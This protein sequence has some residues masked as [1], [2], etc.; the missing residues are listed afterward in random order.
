[1][2]KTTASKIQ[3]SFLAFLILNGLSMPIALACRLEAMM[4]PEKLSPQVQKEAQ[5]FYLRS[6][7][8]DPNSL[9]KE[10][11]KRPQKDGRSETY[12]IEDLSGIIRKYGNLDGWGL[13]GYSCPIQPIR[14]PDSS[15]SIEP[16]VSDK[17][18]QPKVSKT[19]AQNPNIIM[20]HVRQAPPDKK[21]VELENVHPFT[22]QSWSLM[23]NGGAD[24]AF[25]PSIQQTI[26]R[27]KAELGGGPKGNT[28][29][30]QI[31][32]YFLSTLL[33]QYGTTDSAKLTLNQTQA[34]FAKTMADIVSAS[35]PNAKPIHG[36]VI[37][38]TGTIQT[39]P[40]C[41]FIL[42]DGKHLLAFRKVL[43]LFLG[44]KTLPNGQK[45]YIIASEKTHVADRT[46]Q[47]LFLPEDHV[48]SISWDK[49]GNPVP[50]LNPITYQKTN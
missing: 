8:D 15:R 32:Y 44:L 9:Q 11:G 18:F 3:L 45:I 24:G 38:V 19:I 41:N 28:D 2:T 36:E 12:D 35:K 5:H 33:E 47:W 26:N 14:L 1:M 23:H 17:L 31:F 39:L 20:A 21:Q 48:L 46:V 29:T 7:V 34:A 10:S 4:G 43:N 25:A 6:L 22:Y 30:E 16:A 27:H 49:T 50:Q 42:S 37:G 40:S 13:V